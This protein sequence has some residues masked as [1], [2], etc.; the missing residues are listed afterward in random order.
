MAFGV[1]RFGLMSR[2]VAAFAVA[3]L[4]AWGHTG[5]VGAQ[6]EE[7]DE[8]GKKAVKRPSLTLKATPAIAFAPAR[9][10]VT[11]ELRGGAEDSPELYCPSLEWEWGDGTKSE[12][13]LDCEPFQ[14]GVS[15]IR[16]R[17]TSS[18]SYDL[19]GNYRVRLRL[20]RGGKTV[21][22]GSTTLQIRGGFREPQ[23]Y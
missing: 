3:A 12:A 1:R 5:S 13:N 21:V 11:A 9:V 6:D 14:A 22:S 17:W 8:N 15:E 19:G 7:Q 18:H 10:V 2:P 4:I 20:R 16:R 23:Q